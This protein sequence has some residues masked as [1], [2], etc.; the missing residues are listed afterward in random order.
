MTKEELIEHLTGPTMGE[1]VKQVNRCNILFIDKFSMC[2]AHIFEQ[3]NFVCQHIR[4]NPLAMG[5][6]RQLL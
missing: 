3:L 1:V 2:S 5:V 6:Y 4:N